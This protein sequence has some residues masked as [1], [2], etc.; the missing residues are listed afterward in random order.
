MDTP[1]SR[2]ALA[3]FLQLAEEQCAKP[4]LKA[5][6]FSQA[7]IEY[8]RWLALTWPM[9]ALHLSTGTDVGLPDDETVRRLLT[10]LRWLCESV[11]SD[12]SLGHARIGAQQHVL[13]WGTQRGV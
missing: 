1:E 11:A 2:R 3:R 6:I 7:D 12:Q 4:V 9:L 10:R 5:V 13:A 8:A